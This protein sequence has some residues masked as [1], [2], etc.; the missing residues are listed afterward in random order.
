MHVV[1]VMNYKGGVGKTTLTAN[2]AAEIANTGYRVLMIDLDPQANL[3]FSFYSVEEWTSELR[4]TR[5]IKRWY[6]GEVPGRD[7]PLEDLILTPERVNERIK[8]NAG[9][10]DLI[11][12][13]LGLIDIDLHLAN[14]LGGT[15]LAES[16]RRFLQVHA[17]LAEALRADR[18]RSYDVVLIDC[19]P[20][21]GLVTKTA[22]VASDHIL[23]PAKPDYLSTL[24]IAYLEGSVQRLV[25]EFNAYVAH[26]SSS[27]HV[28]PI[29]PRFAGVAFTMTQIQ[30][31]KPILLQRTQMEELQEAGVMPVFVPSVRNSPRYFAEAGPSGIPA[32]LLGAINDPVS[33]EVRA[34][35]SAFV[36]TLAAQD[37]RA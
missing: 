34:L 9:Q 28:R 26:E 30:A 11:A 18:F 23:V 14:R 36:A 33:I 5:T 1:S 25:E 22:I 37:E 16:K 31:G 7:V 35:T 13:H 3:T 27:S 19:A 8:E 15:T 17:C 29:S 21:F 24:G 2:I 10:L 6:D 12:S 20:N 32:I 4:E